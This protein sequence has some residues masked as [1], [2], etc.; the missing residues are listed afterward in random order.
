MNR[1][2]LLGSA[3]LALALLAAGSAAAQSEKEFTRTVQLRSGGRLT[4]DTY[5]G[6][7]HLEPWDR[8]EVEIRARIVADGEVS[9]EYAE[10]SVEATRVEVGGSGA[11]V[12]VNSEYD[13]VPCEESYRLLG[14][15]FGGCS[16]TLPMIHYEVRAPRELRLRIDDH[17]S[18]IEFS[19]FSGEFMVESHKGIID[20]SDLTGEFTLN[21]HK[22]R[23]RIVGL[24]G[25]FDIDTHRGEIEI[26]GLAITARSSID[27]HRGTVTLT[28]IRPQGLS[29]RADLGRR[30]DF[31]TDFPITLTARR[32]GR[33]EGDI[34]GGGPVLR[35]ESHRGQ[36]YIKKN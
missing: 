2:I 11:S 8:E 12:R 35:I 16:K 6:T 24:E 19:G 20:A 28:L 29:V 33:M 34:N 1:R 7:I 4:F 22:G 17:K 9:D 10:A 15:I 13:D 31:Q 3:T 5:K 26:E 14:R 36:I 21:T 30:A 18:T 27:T 25:G 32:D 23:A